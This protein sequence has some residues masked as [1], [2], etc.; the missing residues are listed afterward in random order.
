MCF[1]VIAVNICRKCE[2]ECILLEKNVINIL[3]NLKDIETN[4]M[5]CPN[6]DIQIAGFIGIFILNR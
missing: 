1:D 4:L 5:S 2:L 6:E 3:K